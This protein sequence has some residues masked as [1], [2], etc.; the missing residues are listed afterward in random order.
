MPIIQPAIALSTRQEA[1]CRH[2]AASGNAADAARQA[3]YSERSARQTGCALLERPYVVE[4]LRRIRLS[5]KRT[6]RDE[7]QIV[8]AR[9]EQAWDAAVAAGSAYMMLRVLRFQAEIAG[10][11]KP[12]GGTRARLWPVAHEDEL[13]EI[14]AGEALEAGTEPG[15]LAEAVR[16]GRDRAERA[17]ARHR[18]SREA[19]ETQEGFD[20]AAHEEATRRLAAAVEERTRLPVSFDTPD[21]SPA[22]D[23]PPADDPPE[24]VYEDC[25]WAG[26]G[27]FTDDDRADGTIDDDRADGAEHDWLYQRRNGYDEIYDPWAPEEREQRERR[28]LERE[29]RSGDPFNLDGEEDRDDDWSGPAT[30]N[31]PRTMTEHDI[32]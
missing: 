23:L 12:A 9:L 21:L 32:A 3:G 16:R 14:G 20:V 29:Q 22:N 18:E 17:L 26:D 24:E 31:S 15:P 2:Y 11:V 5:W 6:E 19:M 8:L 13:G 4:R 7:A 10:L 30:G 1:F 28:R 25:P 27:G